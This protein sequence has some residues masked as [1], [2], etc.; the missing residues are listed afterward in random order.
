MFLHK[1]GMSNACHSNPICCL[2]QYYPKLLYLDISMS[3]LIRCWYEQASFINLRNLFE[4]C[5][6]IS[7]A[8]KAGLCRI[9]DYAGMTVKI[10]IPSEARIQ[11]YDWIPD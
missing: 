5:N 7:L 2:P 3:L 8:E 10:V 1:V 11:T 6:E 4:D 9:P